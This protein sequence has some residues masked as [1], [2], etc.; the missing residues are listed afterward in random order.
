MLSATDGSAFACIKAATQ[1]L[2]TQ[3]GLAIATSG[4]A[5]RGLRR[6]SI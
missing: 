3:P 1:V 2:R 6:W 5:P 4:R